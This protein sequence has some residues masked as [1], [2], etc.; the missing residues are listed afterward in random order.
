MDALVEIIDKDVTII[1]G[2]R[3]IFR[4]ESGEVNNFA[5]GSIA[6]CAFYIVNLHRLLAPLASAS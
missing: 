3:R 4:N 6:I 5:N 1:P 2:I